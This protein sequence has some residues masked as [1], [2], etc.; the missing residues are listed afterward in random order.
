MLLDEELPKGQNL[1]FA[2]R[3]GGTSRPPGQ[4]SPNSDLTAR[5]EQLRNDALSLGVGRALFL[6]KGMIAWMRAWSHCT[7]KVAPEM[8]ALSSTAPACSI[9]IRSQI[10]A[11]LV[12]MILGR[13][14]EV[15][16]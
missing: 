7:Q 6:R 13:Q 4:Q 9:D 11:L 16:T 15:A 1:L 2:S 10:A 12:G 3:R 8:A 14:S 5:Y